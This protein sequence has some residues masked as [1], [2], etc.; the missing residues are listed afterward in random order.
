MY[1]YAPRGIGLDNTAHIPVKEGSDRAF[2]FLFALIFLVIAVYPL[3]DST[4][5]VRVWASAIALLLWACG[6]FIPRIFHYPNRYWLKLG[7]LLGRITSPIILGIVFFGLVT[8]IALLSRLMGS[9]PLRVGLA[10][11]RKDTYWIEREPAEGKPGEGEAATMSRQ[12]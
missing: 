4:G 1:A 2:A 9:D 12:Y 7:M 3:A 5:G 11:K 6:A 10:V 8:P